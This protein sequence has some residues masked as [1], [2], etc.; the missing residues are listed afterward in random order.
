MQVRCTAP[1]VRRHRRR[2]CGWFGS[3]TAALGPGARRA[4]VAPMV[5]VPRPARSFTSATV[6][7]E[8]HRYQCRGK[9]GE[10]ERRANSRQFAA[11]V[12]LDAP[13]RLVT[14]EE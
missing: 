5:T 8:V 1:E 12:H 9:R 10:L 4:Q 7:R 14:L 6:G 11:E 2:N 13:E 3:Q